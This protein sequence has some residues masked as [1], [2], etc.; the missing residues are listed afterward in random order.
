MINW[1]FIPFLAAVVLLAIILAIKIIV[2][3][4]EAASQVYWRSS[5]WRRWRKINPHYGPRYGDATPNRR[6]A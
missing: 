2:V 3:V 1:E 6:R 4:T 5:Q